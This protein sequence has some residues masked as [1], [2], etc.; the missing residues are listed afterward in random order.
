MTPYMVHF[1]QAEHVREQ[2][3][4]VL[5][6]AYNVHPERFV[7]GIPSLAPLPQAVWINPPK[8]TKEDSE[9]LH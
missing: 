8:T 2:R 6:A 7:K 5:A 9:R 4:L 1:G 3:K